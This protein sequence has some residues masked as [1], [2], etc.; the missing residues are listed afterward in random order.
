[1]NNMD[2]KF[3]CY[4]YG[5]YNVNN[6]QTCKKMLDQLNSNIPI[7][8]EHFENFCKSYSKTDSCV[9]QNAN[10]FFET[11]KK[12]LVTTN[13]INTIKAIYSKY[14][15]HKLDQNFDIIKLI[16]KLN[17]DDKL[18]NDK[19]INN[20]LINDKLI[21]D[22]LI[23]DKLI[24][25]NLIND[26]LINDNLINDKYE[27]ILNIF[28]NYENYSTYLYNLPKFNL[29]IS[30][31]DYFIECL[32]MIY[33]KYCELL[34]IELLNNFYKL[35]CIIKYNNYGD[36]S[37]Y[38]NIL[39][40]LITKILDNKKFNP[41]YDTF[42]F[43]L[44]FD[45]YYNSMRIIK[46]SHIK[47]KEKTLKDYIEYL[48][49]SNLQN[50]IDKLG[51]ILNI[52]L[53]NGSK[54]EL[55]DQKIIINNIFDKIYVGKN[56]KIILEL[57]IKNNLNIIF[58]FMADNKVK[59]DDDLFAYTL[60][61]EIKINNV[62]NIGIDLSSKNFTNI[63]FNNKFNPYNIQIALTKDILLEEC[64]KSGNLTKIKSMC[65]EIIPDIKCLEEA[66]KIKN[67]IHVVKYFCE[68]Q[69]IKPNIYCLINICESIY[70][71]G[72]NRW[73]F[74]EFKKDLEK[75]K[76]NEIN[77]INIENKIDIITD[78]NTMNLNKLDDT[79][80]LKSSEGDLLPKKKVIRRVVKKKTETNDDNNNNEIKIENSEGDLLPKKK[81]IRRVVKKKP[82][83]NDDN[84]NNEI[85][86]ENSEGDLLPKKKVI[87]RVVKKKTE[88]NDDNNNNEIKIE[89]SEGDLLPKK[90]VIRRVVKKKPE[91][92]D[93]DRNNNQD[94]KII[95]NK[96]IDINNYI[97]PKTYNYRNN[98]ETTELGK[99]ICDDDKIN[100]I[101]CRYK[102]L[103]HLKKNNKLLNDIELEGIKFKLNEIDKIIPA[104]FFKL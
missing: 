27:Q 37:D 43:S 24:N 32:K 52:L 88:I 19:L 92:N 60:Q 70:Q 3:T 1:M 91:I 25:D 21:N 57:K 6:N 35:L 10:Y 66:C 12:I 86:I 71:Y 63:Y 34:T 90:K 40:E 69:K 72:S 89:K 44:V 78:N 41:D 87:R 79:T 23:N 95:D 18:I 67:N 54:P 82:E 59:F 68:A 47:I 30:R 74:E 76:K 83:T 80:N 94:N 26:N 28:L 2:Y 33:D 55:I 42:I 17:K 73:I 93:E 48:I 11:V 101:D 77:E 20:K 16:L 13:Y 75:I 50:D 97:I 61:S 4:H 7:S 29:I 46:M 9:I 58:N 22:K 81:V 96:I 38:I 39:Y 49:Y 31:F 53:D 99:K 84:N 36:K 45:D 102:L 104:Y 51:I 65:K 98:Y 62:N 15:C 56:G 5:G 85:K 64:K 8:S 14:N 103:N 100:H